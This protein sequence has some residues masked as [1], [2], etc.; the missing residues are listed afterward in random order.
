MILCYRRRDVVGDVHYSARAVPGKQHRWISENFI[1]FGH[2]ENALNSL[3]PETCRFVA[4][5][6]SL[7]ERFNGPSYSRN[8]IN[9]KQSLSIKKLI[10]VTAS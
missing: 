2:A 3:A 1:L 7:N 9:K 8:I 6:I 4:S 10:S 5:T